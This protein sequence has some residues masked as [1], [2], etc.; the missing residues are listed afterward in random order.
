VGDSKW[1][2]GELEAMVIGGVIADAPLDHAKNRISELLKEVNRLQQS[3][4][5]AVWRANQ[6]EAEMSEKSKE[7]FE[8]E[9]QYEEL[10]NELEERDG[11]VR[12]AEFRIQELEA[13]MSEL[14]ARHDRLL[15]EKYV[16][17]PNGAVG[18]IESNA[19]PSESIVAVDDVRL[20]EQFDDAKNRIAWLE[21]QLAHY[22]HL[23]HDTGYRLN[24]LQNT[25][26]I[27]HRYLWDSFVIRREPFIEREKWKLSMWHEN[28]NEH[29]ARVWYELDAPKARH[30][31]LA[32]SYYN[33]ECLL[34]M[35]WHEHGKWGVWVDAP[36]GRHE[37]RFVVDGE[38]RASDEYPKCSNDVESE[39]NWRDV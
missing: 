39:N 16:L 34:L 17:A 36:R 22:K 1:R 2:C 35:T 10:K 27:A 19:M 15:K 12:D 28:S 23:F 29:Y 20:L 14:Q 8:M 38:W 21:S 18:G 26:D 9:K 4:D 5:E 7:L 24:E 30:V 31:Y 13:I 3:N 33:W 37:F 25:L 32:A 6:A 11:K